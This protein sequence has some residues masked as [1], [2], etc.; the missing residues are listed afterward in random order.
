MTASDVEQIIKEL[1]SLQI[2]QNKIETKVDLIHQG[3]YGVPN[4]EEKGFCGQL[5]SLKRDYYSFKHKVV[6]ILAVGAG[7]GGISALVARILGG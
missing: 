3:L 4:S 1:K 5:S 6:I 7:S 2:N